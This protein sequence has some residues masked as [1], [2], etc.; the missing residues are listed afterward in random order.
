MWILLVYNIIATKTINMPTLWPTVVSAPHPKVDE[1]RFFLQG[2][3]GEFVSKL[4]LHDTKSV[5]KEI[6]SLLYANS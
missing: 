1:A 2:K 5:Y 6:F 3:Y 4:Q